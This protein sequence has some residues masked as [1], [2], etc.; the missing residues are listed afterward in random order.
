MRLW[1]A[2]VYALF[3]AA[4]FIQRLSDDWKYSI[5]VGMER[6]KKKEKVLIHDES[7]FLILLHKGG[8]K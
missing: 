7:N 1:K 4:F 6:V 8:S 2:K 3:L 5:E